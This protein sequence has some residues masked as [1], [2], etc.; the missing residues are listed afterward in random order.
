MDLQCRR[1]KQQVDLTTWP[2]GRSDAHARSPG[3]P[4]RRVTRV[5]SGQTGPG[6]RHRARAASATPGG[7][8]SAPTNEPCSWHPAPAESIRN[9]KQEPH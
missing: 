3:R 2:A 7:K 5:D 9:R 6:R 1:K 4:A 8:T